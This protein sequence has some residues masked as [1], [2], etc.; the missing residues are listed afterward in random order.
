MN[1]KGLIYKCMWINTEMKSIV[2][3]HFVKK[4]TIH[5]SKKK[6]R[7]NEKGSLKIFSP[8][9]ENILVFTCLSKRWYLILICKQ[10][11]KTE[12]VPSWFL[13]YT[14]ADSVVVI[15]TCS[16]KP[17]CIRKNLGRKI[18]KG[19][20]GRLW[21]THLKYRRRFPLWIHGALK[22]GLVYWKVFALF[23]ELLWIFCSNH[24]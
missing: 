22:I 2:R 24:F 15:G 13:S 4:K 17:V 21:S 20:C 9:C 14:H 5:L 8:V 16:L 23:T 18:L 6:R 19:V 3:I 7:L 1:T 11:W 12:D 10:S